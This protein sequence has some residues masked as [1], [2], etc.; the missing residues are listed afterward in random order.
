MKSS[1][2]TRRLFLLGLIGA[3][4][5]GS[6]VVIVVLLERI[7]E[8]GHAESVKGYWASLQDF[9]KQN[10]RYPKDDAEIA[11]FFHISTEKEP[12][13]YLAPHDDR[14]DEVVLWWKQKTIFGVEVGITESGMIVKK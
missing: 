11:S 14:A 9:V 3:L 2:K 8:F 4:A 6:I 10:G 1:A 7:G 5:L 12:V 13:E